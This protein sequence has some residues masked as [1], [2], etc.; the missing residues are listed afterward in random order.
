MRQ[1]VLVRVGGNFYYE[2][3]V[4]FELNDVPCVW[5]SRDEQ[6]NLMLNFR[7]PTTSGHARAS[8]IENFW[9]V[10]SDVDELVCPPKCRLVEVFYRSGDKFKAEFF[11]VAD[12]RALAAKYPGS[13][14]ESW[15]GD[16]PFPLTVAEVWETAAGTDVEFG[17]SHSKVGGVTITEC[18]MSNCGAGIHVG[19]SDAQLR[20][21]FPQEPA[22][23]PHSH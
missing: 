3:P 20:A 12:P 1:D 4:I 11:D 8:I 2:T 15:A 19:V 23:E 17:P 9:S 13:N 18:F 7:M 22:E 16:L 21:L 6:Q 14:S 10:P 5:L